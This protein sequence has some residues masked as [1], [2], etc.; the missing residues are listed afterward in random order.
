MSDKFKI[1]FRDGAFSADGQ[2]SNLQYK[3]KFTHAVATAQKDIEPLDS[4][5][6]FHALIIDGDNYRKP[7]E[8]SAFGIAHDGD[9]HGEGGDV[10]LSHQ[11]ESAERFLRELRGFGLLA[12]VVGSGKTFEAGVILSELAVRGKMKSLMIVAPDQVFNTWVDVLENKFGMGKDVLYKVAKTGDDFP[13]LREVLGKTGVVKSGKFVRPKRPLIVDADIFAQWNYERD[14]LVDIIVVDEAHH[15]C[16]D[17]GKYAGAMRLL[18]EMMQTK[19]RAG[20]AYCLLLT[21]TPHSGNLENMFRLWYFVRCKG[22]IPSD[23]EEK[24]DADRTEQYRT[25]KEYYKNTVCYGASNVSEF[26]R[27]VKYTVVMQRYK[28]ELESYLSATGELEKFEELSVY[29][30]D[31]YIDRFLDDRGDTAVGTKLLADGSR[32]KLLL[33]S[34]V[35]S[36][37][38]AAYHNGVL[39]SIMIRQPNKLAKRKTVHNYFFFPMTEVKNVVE[40]SGP[41]GGR[42]TVDF[43]NAVRSGSPTVDGAPLDMYIKDARGHGSYAQAFSHMFNSVM[44]AWAEADENNSRIHTK[45]GYTKYYAARFAGSPKGIAENTHILPVPAARFEIGG[46]GDYKFAQAVKLLKKHRDKRVLVFFDYD[47]PK[48]ELICDKVADAMLGD[49]ELKNRI[50]IGDRN[51]N[52]GEIERKFNSDEHRDAI[53]IVKDPK[54]TE[55]ANLQESNIIVN[56]QVTYD[57]LAMDQRIGRIFRLGQKND[58]IV[59]SLADMNKLEGFALAYFGEIGLL[60]GNSGDAT[61]LAGSNSEQMVALRCNACGRVKLMSKEEY[62]K[63]R[64]ETPGELV[65]R[66]EPQCIGIGGKG[67]DMCEITVYDF[68]CD[69]CGTVLTRSVSEGYMCIS[70]VSSGERGRMCNSG[71]KGDRSVYCRKICAISHCKRFNKGG[72]LFG[73]CPALNRYNELG[74]VSDADLMRICAMCDNGDCREECRIAGPAKEQIIGEPGEGG[75]CSTCEYAG[76]DPKPHALDFN[77]KW[78]ADCPMQGCSMHRPKGKLRPVVARTFATFI[79]ELWKFDHDGGKGFCANLGLQAH[80]VAEIRRILE[81]DAEKLGE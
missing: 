27:R 16:E 69:S 63:K 40:C 36:R 30:R 37:V 6:D 32:G 43:T 24:D 28:A 14:F 68:K 78:E 72:K 47:L 42:V 26:I 76:C 52:V 21:A 59:Y 58:V 66:E 70:H 56:Y 1:T 29:D 35:L 57:P 71:E 17:I 11:S 65:C 51:G 73:K 22:G 5:D 2:R 13:S 39:R 74:N 7:S 49:P 25:E 41:A 10:I 81:N 15:L 18:S 80:K 8:R 33:R 46:S 64:R 53:L 54:F 50:I 34:D 20:A 12:D 62:E 67:T 44:N 31:V 60:S 19:K 3:K 4:H 79:S 38:S 61:I 75:R 45:E 23:F 48:Y 55:G 77:D 9:I